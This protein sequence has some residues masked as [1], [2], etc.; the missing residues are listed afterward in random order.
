MILTKYITYYGKI[1]EVK[2][3]S[4]N[5]DIKVDVECPECGDMRTVC[6]KSI[7]KAGHTICVKCVNKR[8]AKP[9]KTGTKYGRLVVIK[10]S[11]TGYSICKCS[12]GKTKEIWNTNLRNGHTNS[13][14]CLKTESFNNVD[15]VSEESHGMWKGGVTRGREKHMSQKVYKDWRR[16]VYERDN[17]TCQKC[18]NQSRR[19]NAHHLEGYFNCKGKQ[20][21]VNN[22]VTLCYDCHMEFHKKYGK[23]EFSS[24]NYYE[25]I[26]HKIAI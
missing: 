19:L 24:D 8:N 18:G 9:I 16:L 22:G 25:F 4:P 6:Y 14:G 2:D 12:C 21:D 15:R 23:K 17:Y 26:R 1:K 11:K 3:L 7:Y 5:S 20:T 10:E 13:C